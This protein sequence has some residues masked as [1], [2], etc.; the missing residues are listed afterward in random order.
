VDGVAV[1]RSPGDVATVSVTTADGGT[2]T[3]VPFV[4]ADLAD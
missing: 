2:S 1:I 4:E 3:A